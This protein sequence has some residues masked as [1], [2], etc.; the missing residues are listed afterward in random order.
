MR[1]KSAV[2]YL[3]FE[4]YCSHIPLV[5]H[6]L[7][8]STA[9]LQANFVLVFLLLNPT[10]LKFRLQHTGIC[11]ALLCCRA[12]LIRQ[13]RALQGRQQ[14][15]APAMEKAQEMQHGLQQLR[16]QAERQRGALAAASAACDS[17][18]VEV[19]RAKRSW[20][21]AERQVR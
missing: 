7:M 15:L 3:T 14:R 6:W 19:V 8:L 1:F 4:S 2:V 10:A 21:L 16:A 17:L 11:C 5:A 18:L 9:L 12:L 13:H 20:A